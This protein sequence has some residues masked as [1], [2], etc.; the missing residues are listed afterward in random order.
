MKR[1]ATLFSGGELAGIGIHQAGYELAWG[2]ELL[3]EI[4]AVAMHNLGHN[5]YVG[6]ILDY[7]PHNFP[8]VDGLHASP[9]CPSFS[10]ANHGGVETEL[11][12]ALAHATAWFI[13]VLKP[14]FVTIENVTAYRK[15][16][17][18]AKIL[19]AL[20]DM[21]YFVDARNYLASN[22][23]VPQS[24]R[25]LIVRASRGLFR[26]V[27]RKPGGGWYAAVEDLLPGCPDDELADWQ[28]KA[29]ERDGGVL[30]S[31][32]VESRS[33]HTVSQARVT[34]PQHEGAW[35]VAGETHMPRAVLVQSKN[36][37]KQSGAPISRDQDTPAFVTMT[38]HPPRV[39][40]IDGNNADPNGTISTREATE[41]AL[42]ITSAR[43]SAL[44]RAVVDGV[45]TVQLT[46]RCLA[47]FQTVPDWYE[48]PEK[49]ALA[50]KILGNG[51]PCELMRRVW[52]SF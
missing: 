23:G 39:V 37:N 21:G 40:L 28:I 50:I 16:E 4:A 34:R 10:V 35:F 25:R 2:L 27:G 48:L 42:T 20:E 3:P 31:L 18:Y 49:R 29:I 47:R 46:P 17:S 26:E 8:A 1:V 9:P 11:D 14:E 13:R 38:N 15:S 32:L 7:D 51:V 43:S 30:G 19:G 6:S 41:S 24:R 33:S 52:V 12:K 45:R 5:V 44:P 22:Y 36:A